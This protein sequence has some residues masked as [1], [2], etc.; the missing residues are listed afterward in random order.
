MCYLGCQGG[1][2]WNLGKPDGWVNYK[3]LT[4][5]AAHEIKEI[6]LNENMDIDKAMK[7]IENVDIRIKFAAFERLGCI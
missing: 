7:K 4:D 5:K 3:E 6:V 1:I 2:R